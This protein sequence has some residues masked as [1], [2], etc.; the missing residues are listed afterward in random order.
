MSNLEKHIKFAIYILLYILY[1]NVLDL[2]FFFF[3]GYDD[4]DA[5]N[6]RLGLGMD[7]YLVFLWTYLYYKGPEG[8]LFDR[9]PF[10]R[11]FK[12][13]GLA[14]IIS[15]LILKFLSEKQYF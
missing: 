9:F 12:L 11:I 13:I 2:D 14:G 1:V 15:H 7:F 3:T 10:K 6:E 8:S 5:F 4:H